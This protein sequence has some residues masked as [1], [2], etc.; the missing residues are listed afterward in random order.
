M[1]SAS[2]ILKGTCQAF[3]CECADCSANALAT[4]LDRIV[5][6]YE[7]PMGGGWH[8]E[9]WQYLFYVNTVFNLNDVAVQ[10]RNVGFKARSAIIN[11]TTAMR[12]RMSGGVVIPPLSTE[13][14]C[15]IKPGRDI[16][17]VTADLALTINGILHVWVTEEDLDPTVA[18][19]G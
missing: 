4:E 5:S 17:T 13:F 11:N 2:I 9:E 12:W 18:P 3:M 16:F 6:R 1:T 15:R 14:V 19:S 10:R 7:H 8:T